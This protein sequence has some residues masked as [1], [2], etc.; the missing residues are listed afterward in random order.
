MK[1]LQMIIVAVGVAATVTPNVADASGFMVARFGGEQGHPTTSH[2]SAIYFNPA[3]LS[4]NSGTRVY[5]EGLF[6]TRSQG[7]TRPTTAIDNVVTDGDPVAGTPTSATS[8]NAGEAKLSNL[9]AAPFAAVVSDLG[10]KNLGVAAGI[11]VPFGGSASWDENGEYSGDDAYPGAVDGVQRWSNIEGEIQSL[12]ATLA[13]SYY[14]PKLRLA[15]GVGFNAVFTKSRNIRARNAAGTDDLLASNGA[16][17]EGRASLDITGTSMSLGAGVIW[18]PTDKLRVGVSYQSRPNF[19][20]TTLKGELRAKLSLATPTTT[21]IVV[22]WPLPDVIRA[23]A[24]FRPTKRT[25][26]RVFGD[27]TRWS[28]LDNHCAMAMDSADRGCLLDDRG[29]ADPSGASIV[30]NIPRHWEDAFGLRVGGSYWLSEKRE[31]FAGL[32]YD[33]NAIPDTTIGPDITD[34]EKMTASLGGRMLLT[35]E[36]RLSLTFTQVIYFTRDVEVRAASP[37][38]GISRLPDFAGSYTQSVSLFNLGAEYM[39]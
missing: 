2:P 9:F 37:F 24:T 27:F 34:Q 25:E 19:G 6:G 4:L 16:M 23:G 3:G 15:V 18:Q 5:V 8:A 21:D 11:Y 31:L 33:G 12:Y 10:I 29:N 1:R 20:T 38:D 22:R 35:S 39:F 36:L 14:F 28:V 17:Q 7:Y 30:F 32:G 26:V 13:G